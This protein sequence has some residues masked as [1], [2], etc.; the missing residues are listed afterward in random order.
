MKEL[1]GMWLIPDAT[2]WLILQMVVPA[3]LDSIIGSPW[4]MSCYKCPAATQHMN[5]LLA[6]TQTDHIVISYHIIMDHSH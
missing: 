2:L 4:K 1:Y 5:Q 6:Q 3:V